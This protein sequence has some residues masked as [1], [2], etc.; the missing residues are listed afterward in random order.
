PLPAAQMTRLN[1]RIALG[2]TKGSPSAKRKDRPRL[3]ER[4]VRSTRF[5]CALT[6][7]R[8]DTGTARRTCRRLQVI[9]RRL[10]RN[11]HV[12]HVALAQPLARDADE[13]PVFAQIT[14]GARRGVAHAGTEPADELL[15][16]A[17]ERAAVRHTALDAFGDELFV[18]CAGLSVAILAAALHRAERAHAAVHLVTSALV[19]HELSGRFVGAGEERTDHNAGRPRGARLRA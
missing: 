12:V 2:Q 3:N 5:L 8:G 6:A 16:D 7:A 4:T 1:E 15:H 18:R 9:I 19:E 14:E 13:L 17:R 10:L 11:H